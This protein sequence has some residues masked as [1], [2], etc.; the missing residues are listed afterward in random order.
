MTTFQ[1]YFIRHGLAGQ[2]GDYDDDRQRPLTNA[3]RVKTQQVVDGLKRLDVKCDRIFTSPYL[4]AQQTAEILVQRGLGD[5]VEPVSALEPDG[6]FDALLAALMALDR[7]QDL[8]VAIVGHEPNLSQ[9]AEQ[10]VWG[11]V[12]SRLVLKKAG[13]IFLEGPTSGDIVGECMLRWLV[14]PKVL[15]DS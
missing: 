10:L 9:A 1:L 2:L 13:V 11:S 15:L 7:T 5:Q 14:A 8:S 12:R 6:S 4:R 3:G